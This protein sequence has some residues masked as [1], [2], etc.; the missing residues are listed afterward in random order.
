MFPALS[1]NRWSFRYEADD[2]YE[3]LTIL[4]ALKMPNGSINFVSVNSSIF[5]FLFCTEKLFSMLNDDQTPWE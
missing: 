5:M 1:C 3:D 4:K 2:D